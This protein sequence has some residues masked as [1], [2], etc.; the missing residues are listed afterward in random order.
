MLAPLKI[1]EEKLSV[2]I[3]HTNALRHDTQNLRQENAQ[4]RAQNKQLAERMSAAQSHIDHV[5]AQIESQH[6]S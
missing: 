6:T 1:L 3:A 5:I 2:L 4:L